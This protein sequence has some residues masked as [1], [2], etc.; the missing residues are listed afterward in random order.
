MQY[1]LL[2]AIPVAFVLSIWGPVAQAAHIGR[3]KSVEGVSFSTWTISAAACIAWLSY[4]VMI[5]DPLQIAVNFPALV[6]SILICVGVVKYRHNVAWQ[7]PVVCVAAWTTFIILMGAVVGSNAVGT[8]ASVIALAIFMP[9]A[10]EA[11][12][13]PGGQGISISSYAAGTIS[14]VAWIVYGIS[15]NDV[16]I[17]GPSLIV[18]ALLALICV[19]TWQAR[20]RAL[21]TE[22]VL[23]TVA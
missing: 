2:V 17:I 23:A 8:L 22:P 1:A 11:W 18:G 16:F 14:K 4:G 12:K 13:R 10:W 19:R 15:T 6:A 5:S 9:Q 21:V 20:R 3:K 7:K